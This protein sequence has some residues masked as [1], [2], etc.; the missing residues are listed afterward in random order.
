MQ[1]VAS[2]ADS[3]DVH[4][5]T[6]NSP[7]VVL[8]TE[9]ADDPRA[10]S[11]SDD[12]S[13]TIADATSTL[14]HPTGAILAALAVPP[15]GF[16]LVGDVNLFGITGLPAK[17][18]SWHGPV[19]SNVVVGAD[20]PIYD[21]AIIDGDFKLSNV[22]PKLKSTPFDKIVLHN[23]TFT[24]Q[25]YL[26]D[27]TK[28]IGW[29]VGADYT[30]DPSCGALYDVLRTVL[31]VPE[32]TLH[33]NAGLGL[34]QDWNTAL[35]VSS[36]ALSGTFPGLQAKICD[37]LMLTSVGA[38]LLAIRSMEMEPQPHSVIDYGFGVFGTLAVTV[39]G[40][41]TPLELDCRICEFGGVVQLVADLNGNVWQDPLGIK[42]LVVRDRLVLTGQLLSSCLS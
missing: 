22:I 14:T 25:N 23:V 17:M 13:S 41:I 36:F 12:R 37:G 24:H 7:T 11:S 38:E 33:L 4:G 42:G 30:I 8:H 21:E 40:S 15:D 20:A 28:P 5:V 19:P 16:T 32:P 29:N 2:G 3:V 9:S 27:T 35:K 34:R 26:F 10:T 18:Y 31:N 6:I 39:P 1:A